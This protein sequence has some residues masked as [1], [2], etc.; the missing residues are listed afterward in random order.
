M[1]GETLQERDQPG[2]KDKSQN[3]DISPFIIGYRNV[4]TPFPLGID[5]VIVDFD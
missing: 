2:R 4:K 3:N 5:C 1:K